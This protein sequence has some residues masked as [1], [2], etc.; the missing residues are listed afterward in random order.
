MKN[1]TKIFA[2]KVPN[3]PFEEVGTFD[4]DGYRWSVFTTPVNEQG[5]RAVKV[6]VLGHRPRKAN[7]W[8]GWDGGRLAASR[9]LGVMPEAVVEATTNLMKGVLC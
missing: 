1:E 4:A 3:A 6:I 7:F 5:W 9:D 2:G 8:S